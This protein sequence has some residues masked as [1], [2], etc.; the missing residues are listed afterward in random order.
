MLLFLLTGFSHTRDV[1]TSQL[2]ESQTFETGW[3][4][5]FMR[6]QGSPS[7][8]MTGNC[9]SFV[10]QDFQ[11]VQ[12]ASTSSFGFG[13]WQHIRVVGTKGK[14]HK[15]DLEIHHSELHLWTIWIWKGKP[16]VH[17][18]WDPGECLWPTVSQ[19]DLPAFFFEYTVRIGRAVFIRQE[20]IKPT[21]LWFWLHAGLSH[22]FL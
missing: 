20:C 18:D 14:V 13:S 10:L 2:V 3:W 4:G 16:L 12:M 22:A 6:S 9:F 8:A 21:R 1:A 5:L 11:L 7:L 19:L 15:V 17:L